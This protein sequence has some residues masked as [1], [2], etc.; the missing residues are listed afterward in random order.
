MADLKISQLTGATTPLAG[1]EVLPIVQSSTTKKVSVSDLT[2]G[3]TVSAASLVT[4]GNIGAKNAAPST[5]LMVNTNAG[6]EPTWRGDVVVNQ[7][8]SALASNAGIEWKVDSGAS[9]YGGRI[10]SYFDGSSAYNIAIQMR[11]NSA[12]WTTRLDLLTNGDVTV[13]TGNL[14]IGTSGKGID[15]SATPGT[16][17]SELL[18]DYEEG[19]WTPDISWLSAT[20]SAGTYTKIGRQVTVRGSLTGAALTYGSTAIITDDLPFTAA[21]DSVGIIRAGDN[22][23]GGITGVT[24][25]FIVGVTPVTVPVTTLVFTATYFV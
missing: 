16:G 18:D 6:G 22:S 3:R 11:N 24:G 12:A 20:S 8:G 13:S 4:T 7:T 5:P 25:N 21:S 15:F 1:S 19:T 9:G 2:S 23:Q 10:L 17:T 14:V